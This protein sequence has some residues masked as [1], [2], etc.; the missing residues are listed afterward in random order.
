MPGYLALAFIVRVERSAAGVALDGLTRWGSVLPKPLHSSDTFLTQEIPTTLLAMVMGLLTRCYLYPTQ[1]CRR[2]NMAISGKENFFL[3]LRRLGFLLSPPGMP[4]LSRTVL[5]RMFRYADS[6]VTVRDFDG[7]MSMELK[8]SEHMQRRIFWMG[9]YSEDIGSVLD[10]MLSPGM[11]VLDI[12]ANIGEVTLLAA[13]RVGPQGKVFAFEPIDEIADQL[14]RHLRMNGL[15]Q[16]TVERS[17]LSDVEGEGV[18]IYL[19]C[20]QDVKDGHSGLGSL[21]GGEGGEIPLQRIR[22]TT[23]DRWVSDRPDIQRID[24]I[25]IDIEGAELACLRG[26]AISLARFRP[27]IIVEIQDFTA[28]RAGYRST[29]ILNLL[30]SHGYEFSR[31]GKRGALDPIGPS[32][33]RDFQNVLCTPSGARDGS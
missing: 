13:K 29:D 2:A 1:G 26:A 27:R 14:N 8:L 23:L 12:G 18:P 11:T 10:N 15:D 25:K 21:Y 6:T 31:I 32:E 16:A 22:T 3:L 19:S 7:D 17:A 24:L 33:L 4:R 20:G 9:R 5:R 28:G 30:A